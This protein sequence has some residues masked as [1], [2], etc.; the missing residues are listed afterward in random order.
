MSG[1]LIEATTEKIRELEAG[2]KQSLDN[3]NNIV[4]LLKYCQ[5][6]LQLMQINTILIVIKDNLIGG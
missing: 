1:K 3:V 4:A 2:V 5:V 6:S